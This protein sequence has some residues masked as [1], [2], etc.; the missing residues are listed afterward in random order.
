[1]SL[2]VDFNGYSFR[3]ALSYGCWVRC[4]LQVLCDNYLSLNNEQTQWDATMLSLTLNEKPTIKAMGQY[5]LE[6]NCSDDAAAAMYES[7]NG[8]PGILRR[9]YLMARALLL[10]KFT[11]SEAYNSVNL[12]AGF[13]ENHE[14][15]WVRRSAKAF[16][17]R[18]EQY[19]CHP[20]FKSELE[21]RGIAGFDAGDLLYVASKCVKL[22]SLLYQVTVFGRGIGPLGDTQHNSVSDILLNDARGAG[23]PIS[24]KF[25][26][27]EDLIKVECRFMPV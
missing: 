17:Q 1:M 7:C 22:N 15:L 26:T 4:A 11:E 8:D 5:V 9:F 10:V 16:Q 3:K 14:H 25:L 13:D 27:K 20:Q 19:L 23:I 24:A 6:H 2:D 21:S 18:Y 12:F